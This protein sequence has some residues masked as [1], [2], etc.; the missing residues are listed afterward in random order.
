VFEL[1]D[2]G[3]ITKECSD[4]AIKKASISKN[5]VTKCVD[6]SYIQDT[7][8]KSTDP[9]INDNSLL[10]NERAEFMRDGIFF[11]PTIIINK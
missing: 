5:D 11:Y 1:C 4:N 7:N 6:D 8:G 9:A 3:Y 2:Y 10:K